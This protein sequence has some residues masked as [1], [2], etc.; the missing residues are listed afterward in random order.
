TVAGAI[1]IQEV[2]KNTEWVGQAGNAPAYAPHLRKS[3]LRGM[4]AKSMVLQFAR[5]DQTGGN[6]NN[7]RIIRAGDLADRTTFYRHD[8][9]F[10][11]ESRLPR[12]PHVFL[13]TWIISDIPLQVEIARGAQEHVARFFASD[14]KEIIPP[15]PARFFEVPIALPLPEDLGF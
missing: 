6:P 14:G 10:V 1:E 15:E 9:A 2:I 7:S 5:G 11:E 3:P 8:L 4:P 12:A 13:T